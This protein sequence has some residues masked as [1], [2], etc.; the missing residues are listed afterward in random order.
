MKVKQLSHHPDDIQNSQSELEI[1]EYP[2]PT[3]D[4]HP[5]L[6]M[7]I[8]PDNT[9][10]KLAPLSCVKSKGDSNQIL[11]CNNLDITLNDEFSED[12]PSMKNSFRTESKGL[13]TK[14]QNSVSMLNASFTQQETQIIS[15]Q[16]IKGRLQLQPKMIQKIKMAPLLS[17][18]NSNTHKINL[19]LWKDQKNMSQEGK[20]HQYYCIYCEEIYKELCKK[21][22]YDRHI[23]IQDKQCIYCKQKINLKSLEKYKL[24][25]KLYS[26]LSGMNYIVMDNNNKNNKQSK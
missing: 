3:D 15:E 14:R 11:K 17:K 2:Y 7:E 22:Y 21:N 23:P 25:N 8:L 1:I 18:T 26:S 5:N 20:G 12:D 16:K 24:N 19:K 4:T 13:F 10:Q 9:I 6:P